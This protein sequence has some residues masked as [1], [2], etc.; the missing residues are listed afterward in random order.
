MTTWSTGSTPPIAS[1]EPDVFAAIETYGASETILAALNDNDA[2]HVYT[3][4][5]MHASDR[6]TTSGSFAGCQSSK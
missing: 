1:L 2:G 3:G 4:T 6:T 5:R